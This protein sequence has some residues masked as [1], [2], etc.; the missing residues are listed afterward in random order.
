MSFAIPDNEL[1][2]RAVRAGGP[3]GQ[4]VN[5]TSTRVEVLWDVGQS[6]VLSDDQ[7]RLLLHKLA[8]RIGADGVL[9]V[10]AGARRSQLQNRAAAVQRIN[11]LV[12]SALERPTPRKKTRPPRRAA[13][14][15]LTAKK[16]RSEVKERRRRVD[17]ENAEGG[18]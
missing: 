15:R 12:Q 3:G 6:A 14:E 8:N 7:R 13:E 16:K 5:K 2:F 10:A 1:R 18:E 11:E 4:H 9:R 17:T